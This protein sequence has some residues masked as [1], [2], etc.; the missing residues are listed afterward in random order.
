MNQAT[1]IV[2]VWK[3]E[4]LPN[5]CTIGEFFDDN[6]E[7]SDVEREEIERALAAD[8]IWYGGGG[9]QPEYSVELDQ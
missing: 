8:G 4:G 3:D 2:F 9:A 6:E 7:M 5:H 1:A